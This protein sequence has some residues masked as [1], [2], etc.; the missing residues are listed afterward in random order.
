MLPPL[1]AIASHVLYDAT[2]EMLVGLHSVPERRREF[3]PKEVANLLE[4]QS[5]QSFFSTPQFGRVDMSDALLV[6]VRGLLNRLM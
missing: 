5:D 4:I 2:R 1:S 6:N 3:S